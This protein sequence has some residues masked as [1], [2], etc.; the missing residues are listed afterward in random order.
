[1]SLLEVNDL[2]VQY[3]TDDEPVHAVNGV[4]FNVDEG[5]N[6]GL[7]GESGSGKSTVAEAILGLLPSNGIV[8][9][10]EIKFQGRDLLSLSEKER[11]DVLWE[12]IAF[13]PQSAMDALDPV[14]TTGAQIVQAIKKHRDVSTKAARER[15]RELYDMVGLDPNRI[16][17]YPH[18]FSGGMRQRVTIAM[19]LALEPDLII[20]DEPTTGLDVIV[21]DKIIDQ[22]LEIQERVDSSLLLIT[23]EIGVIAETCDELSILYGGKVMEQGDTRGVLG[24]PAN[25][26]TMGLKNSF[27]EIEALE[28]DA[29][30]IP[31]SPPD[32]AH[33]P[34]G[35]VFRDRCPFSTDECEEAHPPLVDVGGGQKSACYYADDAAELRERSSNP[36]TWGIAST[37]AKN[38]TTGDVILETDDLHKWYSQSQSLIGKL[39]GEE[40]RHVKA[41]DGIDLAVHRSEVLGIAGES[42]CGK[43]TLGETMVLLEKPTGG[44]MTFDGNDVQSYLDG[45][46]KKFREQA[47]F[48]FQDPFDS[49]NPRQTV[50][51]LVSE[52]LA[53]HNRD[54]G[55]VD[56][57]VVDTLE[58]VGL[59]PAEAYLEKY[60]HQLSGGERQ[61]V[62]IAQAL[63][64]D[65]AFI[66]ADEPASMLDVSLKVNLLTLLRELADEEDIG[67]VYISHDL[68]S[69]AQVSD[70]LG[71]MYL[72]RLIELGPT[73]EVIARPQ[74]PYTD[75]LLTAAPEKDPTVDRARVALPGEPPDPIDLPDGCNFAPRCPNSRQDC[76]QNDPDRTVWKE[77]NHSAACYYP[78]GEYPPEWGD[79]EP[80]TPTTRELDKRR[81]TNS[82]D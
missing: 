80:S 20:A 71:I 48:I 19:A 7:A 81:E 16:D 62:S 33:E 17:D 37:D 72:G 78:V 76:Y 35:C 53:I 63:V 69:L 27:P 49:L 43:S 38:A 10:G 56:R 70:R 64:L 3:E 73:Q 2:K 82:D 23:H 24:K 30:S 40:K 28:E 77:G 12:E 6:Y 47:Q 22:I 9:E 31:G 68:A 61:R 45:D 26:Y 42:G 8:P 60:P 18:E 29:V 50:R 79:E 14:M 52:P 41:V 66:V 46:M 13:I 59:D 25:P 65:P 75:A 36:E 67:I 1:M 51:R 55:N 32:L 39:R 15:V 21:E 34:T 57:K 4:S 5:V 58:R 44:D 74:H 54:V 11:Q